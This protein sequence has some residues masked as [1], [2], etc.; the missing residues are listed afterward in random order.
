MKHLFKKL[1]ILSIPLWIYL[2]FFIAFEPNNYFGLK[3][4]ASS[5]API[6]R[7]RSFTANPSDYLILGDSRLAHFD[8]QQVQT[9]SKKTWQNL[10]FGGASLR[11]TLDL[12]E[13]AIQTNPNIKELIIGFSFYTLNQ[14]YDTD[15]MSSLQDTLQNPFAY[16]LNL[17][18]NVN[19]LTS[20]TNWLIWLKQKL[21]G[22]TQL[23]WA[24]AQIE[25][26]TRDWQYPQDYISADGTIYPVHT[27]LAEY[28]ALI[29]PTCQG[30]TPNQQQFQ[31]LLDFASQCQQKGIGLTILLPPMAENVR[32][33][34]CTPL[35]IT[36]QMTQQ[37]LPALQQA[38]EKYNFTLLDYEW[39]N[40]PDF[41]Q[42]RQFFD[43]FH[44]D[45]EY[46]L[47]AFTQMVFGNLTK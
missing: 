35:G 30:W 41:D 10:A 34:I 47:P 32:E 15:R 23:S 21:S 1:C 33:E 39:Q 4:T 17:E 8:M 3:Q 18:Y 26:E 40:P 24:E 20:F 36:Q 31:R 14:K 45:T 22:T 7:I 6:S 19:A 2:A 29:R 44:L 9:I 12:A 16:V 42:D 28:A 43:G 5:T 46:G 37:I 25:R 27:K 11:E 13:F 38:S